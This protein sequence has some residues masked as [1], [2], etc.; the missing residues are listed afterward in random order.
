MWPGNIKLCNVFQGTTDHPR[1]PGDRNIQ[2]SEQKDS[3]PS[4]EQEGKVGLGQLLMTLLVF[5]QTHK[6]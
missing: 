1:V 3:D 5:V 2:P 4:L 6:Y